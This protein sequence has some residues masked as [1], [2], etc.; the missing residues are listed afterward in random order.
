[1]NILIPAILGFVCLSAFYW[2]AIRPALLNSVRY[3]I[4]A[5]RD[6][7]RGLAIDEKIKAEGFAYEH[8]EKTLCNLIGMAP[9]LNIYQFGQFMIWRKEFH[10]SSR[11][12]R[13]KE[14]APHELAE[15]HQ[16][17]IESLFWVLLINSPLGG[18][19]IAILVGFVWLGATVN[20]RRKIWLARHRKRLEER[21]AEFL[22]QELG[23][24]SLVAA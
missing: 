17:A 14:N 4:F 21:G 6:N 10:T 13:F 5:L 22:E 15:M 16:Q 24:P 8:L 2:F 11:E 1:M 19:A 23:G 20:I 3:K 12:I 9:V 18:I 7:L